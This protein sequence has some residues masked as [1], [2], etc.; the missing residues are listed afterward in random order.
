MILDDLVLDVSKFIE[1]HPGGRFVL[2]HNIGRDISKFFHGGYSLEDN[3]GGGSPARGH[4][5][6][7]LARMIVND[8]AIAKYAPAVQVVTTEC[9]VNEELCRDVNDTTKIIVFSSADMRNVTNWK[10]YFR[11][12]SFLGKHYLVR[13]LDNG[14]SVARHYTICNA[15]RPD[16]YN[17]Y[18]NSLKPED[19]PTY[20]AIDPR[21]FDIHNTNTMTFCIKN[22]Q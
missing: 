15:M 12:L 1:E 22:Y 11:D 13:N 16:V 3:L 9:Q 2:Q 20:K 19:D 10:Q 5:H 17:A 18:I 4:A 8:L 21:S 6:S 14:A 7:S